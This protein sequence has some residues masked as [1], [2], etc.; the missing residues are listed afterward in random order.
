MTGS[1]V[2]IQ[3][4]Y[5]IDTEFLFLIKSMGEIEVKKDS[6]QLFSSFVSLNF[7]A[8]NSSLQIVESISNGSHLP[9]TIENISFCFQLIK[10]FLIHEFDGQLSGI[11]K[12]MNAIIPAS[13]FA[14]LPPNKLKEIVLS[15]KIVPIK[16]LIN[17]ISCE[18]KEYKSMLEKYSC[19]S[20]G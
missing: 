18:D 14:M 4:I 5:E 13:I 16:E 15:S 6:L 9:V 2:S 3:Q 19:Q 7:T 17:L 1:G 10:N 8:Q 12:G 20:F 11:K